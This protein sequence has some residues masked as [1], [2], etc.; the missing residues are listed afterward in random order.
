MEKIVKILTKMDD[1]E[2]LAGLLDLRQGVINGI[3]TECLRES[4]GLAICY[5]RKLV[6][7]YCDET[8][9]QV[10]CDIAYILERN[11]ASNTEPDRLKSIVFGKLTKYGLS[12]VSM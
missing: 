5:R 9:K 2:T 4:G 3:K 7:A 11:M 1:W 12:S 6:R 10:A 8:S